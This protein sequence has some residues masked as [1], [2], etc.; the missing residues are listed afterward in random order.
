MYVCMYVCMYFHAIFKILR[1]P[2]FAQSPKAWKGEEKK[3]CI[4]TE[5]DKS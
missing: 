2:R 3:D 5:S 4:N 1:Y